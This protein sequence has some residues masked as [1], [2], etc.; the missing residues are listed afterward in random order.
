MFRR[1]IQGLIKGIFLS[2]R[3]SIAFSSMFVDMTKR[4]VMVGDRL[5]TAVIIGW[6][7]DEGDQINA[8]FSTDWLSC[9]APDTPH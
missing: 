4:V 6:W 8:L 5:L 7:A 3:D 9:E 1:S 2:R